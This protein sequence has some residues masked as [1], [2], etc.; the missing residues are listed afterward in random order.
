MDLPLK[1]LFESEIVIARIRS[2]NEITRP[3]YPQ[4]NRFEKWSGMTHD[5]NDTFMNQPTS[6]SLSEILIIIFE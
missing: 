5:G 6:E 1:T 2:R 3:I 4:I